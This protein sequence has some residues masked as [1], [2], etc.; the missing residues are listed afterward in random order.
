MPEGHFHEILR[1]TDE[2]PRKQMQ[3]SSCVEAEVTSTGQDLDLY[4]DHHGCCVVPNPAGELHLTFFSG[5]AQI[6]QPQRLLPRD[7]KITEI[8]N[9]ILK[10]SGNY[11]SLYPPTTEQISCS[12]PAAGGAD[13]LLSQCF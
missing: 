12:K 13:P 7:E 9:S 11:L 4:G 10:R 5:Q 2:Q 8:G 1:R 6:N 3:T